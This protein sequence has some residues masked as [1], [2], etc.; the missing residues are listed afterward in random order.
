MKLITLNTWS[1][2]L[3]K[4]LKSFIKN[5][6]DKIDIFCFQEIFNCDDNIGQQYLT[7][8]KDQNTNL[9]NNISAILNK[10]NGLFCPVFGEIFGIA[11]FVR[12]SIDIIDFGDI[13]IFENESF[14]F[15][16]DTG[17]D[18][19]R[20]AQWLK[21]KSTNGE[22]MVV[23]VHGHWT[24]KGKSDDDDRI[25]QSEKIVNF[26]DMI[27]LP[28]IV[29]GDFNLLLNTKSIAMIDAKLK[30]LIKEHKI[31]STRTSL[32]KKEERHAD[33]VFVSPDIKVNSF[34]VLPDEVSDHSPLFLD[35]EIQQTN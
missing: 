19:T 24:G 21:L 1:G 30:N 33:Y 12:K 35:F 23:N 29:C 5:H 14:S 27:S 6:S 7:N 22:F 16:D 10:Y 2:K 9:H 4:P 20:K 31:L 26:L 3:D 32:Y 13:T 34:E 28:K 18:H 15:W 11:A 25:K 17:E 8:M